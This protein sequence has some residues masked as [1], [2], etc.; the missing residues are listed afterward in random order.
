V[1]LEEPERIE[2]LQFIYLRSQAAMSKGPM[3]VHRAFFSSYDRTRDSDVFPLSLFYLPC[4][5]ISNGL[6]G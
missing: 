1:L 5:G 2:D 6:P 4:A 3:G